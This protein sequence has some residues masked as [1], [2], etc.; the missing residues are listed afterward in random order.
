[1]RW[2]QKPTCRHIDE[3]Q[4]T[5]WISWTFP[6]CHLAISSQ[7][8]TLR[9]CRKGSRKKSQEKM[10]AWLQNQNQ[11]GIWCRR[12]SLSPPT[13]LSSST[14]QKSVELK[15]QSSNLDLTSAGKLVARGLN[16]IIASSSQDVNPNTGTG[17][18]VANT[19]KSSVGTKLFN[20]N[21]EISPNNVDNL[22]KV[23]K[24]T[25][26]AWSPTERRK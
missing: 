25:T 23:D 4:H 14:P 12:L 26:E 1:M 3:R 22:E 10:N 5:W 18:L 13:V 11:C 20:H 17:I 8:A 9:P 21:L 16:E 6:S 24:R 15:A 19:T 2:Y 7:L